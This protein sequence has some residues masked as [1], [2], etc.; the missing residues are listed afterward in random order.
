MTASP[1]LQYAKHRKI[2]DAAYRSTVI[3]FFGIIT[4]IIYKNTYITLI[5]N[6]NDVII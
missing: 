5:R 1:I 2:W 6:K 3:I 4:G